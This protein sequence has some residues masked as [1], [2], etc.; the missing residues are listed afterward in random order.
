MAA[1]LKAANTPVA[2]FWLQDWVGARKTSVGS[3]LWWNWELDPKRYPEWD[4]LRAEL[5][6]VGARVLSYINPFLVDVSERAEDCRRNLYQEA[7]EK[8]FLVLLP[9]LHV[10]LSW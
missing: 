7:L 6:A 5:E 1:R 3:Q 2:A 10:M 8:G 4:T 9:S